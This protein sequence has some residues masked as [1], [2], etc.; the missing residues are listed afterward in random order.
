MNV[1][2]TELKPYPG[3]EEHVKMTLPTDAGG[4]A[5][6]EELQAQ[7]KAYKLGEGTTMQDIE[8]PGAEPGNTIKLRVITPAAAQKPSPVILDIHGGGFVSGGLDIDNYRNISIAEASS[9]IVVSVE[10][11]LAARDLPF[12]HQLLDCHAAYDW[13]TKSAGEI[14]GDPK[15]IGIHGTSAGGNLAAGLALYLRNHGEQTPA[16]TVLNCPDISEKVTASKLQYGYLGKKTDFYHSVYTIYAAI[17]GQPLSHYASPGECPNLFGL[18]AHMVVA[19]E[20]DPLR[21]EGLEYAFRLLHDR[22]P[23]EIIL[24]PRVTHGFC[25]MDLPLTNWVH[26]GIAASFRREFGLEIRKF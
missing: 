19:A 21:D 26:N 13:L 17:D 4:K 16:L 9:C 18:G 12:P 3:Y 25:V 7:I 23:C 10:Y 20:Y 22:V 5:S 14:G 1:S 8:I 24:A 2:V 15:R 11:R 6:M